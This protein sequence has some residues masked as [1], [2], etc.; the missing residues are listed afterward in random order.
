MQEQEELND[1]DDD[2]ARIAYLFGPEE[3]EHQSTSQDD[4]NVNENQ[5]VE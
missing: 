3:G 4:N 2:S 1:Y 5:A